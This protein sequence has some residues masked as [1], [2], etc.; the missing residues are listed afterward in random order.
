MTIKRMIAIIFIFLLGVAGWTF[1]G[2]V[3]AQRSSYY[4]N[5]LYYQVKQLWGEPITQDSP[6]LSVKIPG[7]KKMRSLLIQGNQ[8][9]VN[10]DLQQRRKGLIWYPTYEVEFDAQYKVVN[11]DAVSQNIRFYFPL[12]AKEATYDRFSFAIDKQIRQIEFDPAVGIYQMIQIQPKQSK[13]V[14]IHYRTR[15]LT[16]WK[17]QLVNATRRVKD[18]DLT[19]TT[20]FEKIDYPVGSLSPMQFKTS[21]QQSILQWQADDLITHQ[22]IGVIMPERI[23][24]GP[25]AA[26]MTFFAPVC[27]LF[28][29]VL[30]STLSVI[31]KIN[32]HPMHYLFV[33]A[34]FFAFHLLFSYL[35]DVINI[36]LAFGISSVVSV[37]LVILYL[38]V[39]LGARFPW[40]IAGLGQ[41]FYLVLFSYSFFIEGMTGLTVTIGSILTLAILMYLT[42]K[43][44]WGQVFTKKTKQ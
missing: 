7:R 12:P 19:I 42:A 41:L 37:S 32:I 21:P 22:D 11:P 34:G 20:N 35:I 14:H 18:L 4:G 33:T 17:Y 28:F 13:I 3:S 30:I 6:T 43:M 27:L 9:K 16:S 40:K 38:S 24:P 36:H 25:L 15:G 29:F 5:Q 1:L 10:L 31:K 8:I 39:A 2:G 44:D 23:N 26:R